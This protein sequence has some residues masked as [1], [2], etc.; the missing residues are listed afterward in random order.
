M[1][2]QDIVQA[3]VVVLAVVI[4]ISVLVALGPGGAVGVSPCPSCVPGQDRASAAARVSMTPTAVQTPFDPG[5]F[6]VWR[7]A[8]RNLQVFQEMLGLKCGPPGAAAVAWRRGSYAVQHAC[9]HLS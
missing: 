7:V 2:L 5:W 8:L 3:L 1:S 9:G 6:S 4:L